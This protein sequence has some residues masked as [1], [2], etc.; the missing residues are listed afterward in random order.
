MS[1]GQ[2]F[3]VAP[4]KQPMFNA[5]QSPEFQQ[6]V[7]KQVNTINDQNQAITDANNDR[8]SIFGIVKDWLALT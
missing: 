5:I 8:G 4:Q 2:G 7:A 1:G 6:K 3:S